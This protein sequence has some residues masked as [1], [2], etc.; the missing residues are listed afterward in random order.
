MAGRRGFTLFEMML[1]VALIGLMASLVVSRLAPREPDGL[2]SLNLYM[3]K[4]RSLAMD[5]GPLLI[6]AKGDTLNL[7]NLEGD[8]LEGPD[9]PLG[10]WTVRPDK[11][12]V[13]KDGTV[14]PATIELDG[15][16][17]KETFLLAVTARVYEAPR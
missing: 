3:G 14:T 9:L 11:I 6:E 8:D 2:S 15:K 10:T 5:S 16:R 13:F 7:T 1:V 12:V 17:G 4:A